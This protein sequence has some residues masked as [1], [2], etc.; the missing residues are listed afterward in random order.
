ML[1]LR[2]EDGAHRPDADRVRDQ[3]AV[4]ST[5]AVRDERAYFTRHCHGLA[6]AVFGEAPAVAWTSFG[7]GPDDVHPAIAP[8]VLVGDHA[9]I[10][11]LA[12]ELKAVP[13]EGPSSRRAFAPGASSV[14]IPSGSPITSA[15]AVSD[16]MIVF[17]ADDGFLFIAGTGEARP[18]PTADLGVWRSRSGHADGHDWPSSWGST[19]N[20]NRIA[21]P[22]IA[23]P[24][25][26]R[27][28]VRDEGY[29]KHPPVAV[30]GDLFTCTLGGFVACREQE[31]GRLRWRTRL[32]AQAWSRATPLAADGRLFVPRVL[33]P[34]YPVIEGQR[35]ALF[36]LDQRDGRILWSADTGGSN[37]LRASPV[38]VDGVV[39]YGS[40]YW[41]QRPGRDDA[42]RPLLGPVIEAF[43]AASGERL[44]Q[45]PVRHAGE[46][47]EGP[48]GAAF[49]DR[50]IFSGGGTG[51]GRAGETLAIEPRSGRVLWRNT[52]LWV[53]RT[54][55]PAIAGDQIILSGA[56]GLP[57][58]AIDARTGATAWANDDHTDHLF[59][60]PASIGDGYFTVNN[61]YSGGALRWS[62]DDG[63]P[64]IADGEPIQLF[65]KGHA[66]GSVL[67]TTDDRAISATMR[68]VFVCD[69]ATG[70]TIW[71]S[72]AFASK[73]CPHPIAA[74]GRLFFHPQNLDVLFC[75]EPVGGR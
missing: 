71:R 18:I 62:L 45:L 47:V 16:G 65:G 2:L 31:T 4:L 24:F 37:W 12:G 10:V 48:A 70:D 14:R 8:P 61:K 32:A 58:G 6:S 54:G 23:P 25:R 19:A 28:A 21:D 35:D 74:G 50:F 38:L 5:P 3:W 49:A 72:P 40:F 7:P 26:L 1:R 43:D 42:G 17:G 57:V 46:Y 9:V 63:Q 11:T 39:A 51:D 30:G 68:G 52:D 29:F 20:D 60:H 75:F 34:R 15:P 64:E 56:Y 67:L 13:L 73:T 59:V 22:R 36:C 44:W 53:C 55:A 69:A 41:P 66:C 33:S 27:W